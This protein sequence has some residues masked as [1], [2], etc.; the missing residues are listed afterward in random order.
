VVTAERIERTA[1]KNLIHN[2]EYIRKVLPFL[3]AEYF[4][5]RNEKIIFS[6]I[7]KFISQYNKPP[8]KETL[9]ID[10]GKRKDL[11]EKEYQNIV[12]LISTLNKEEIDLEWLV[13]TTERFCKDRAIHNAVME[14]I[15]IIDG[16]DKNHTPE[17]I[18][19][20]LKDA[21]AV[22]FDNNVGHDYLADIEKRFDFYHKKE[23]RIAFDLDY[24]NRATKGGLPNK[25]LNVAL[26]GTGVGKTLF[27]CHQAAAALN[28]NKN[29]LYITM[30]M[31]EERIAERIDAN[32]LGVS[33][34]DL[35]MLNK[36]MF[37]DKVTQLQS[38]TTGTVIIKEYP[39]AGAGANHYR[40]LVNE[41]AL[42]K[43]FKP[44]IIFID[45][46]NICAS[47]RFKAGANV[48]S[49]TYIKAIAEELRGLAVEL[50]VPIVTATQTT[51]TGFVSTDI[52]LEDTSES[53][54][55]PAT[56]DFMFAL[57]SSEELEKAGQMLVKQ[58]KNRYNDPTMNRKF[59]IGVDRSRMKLFDIEQS[60]QNLIQ[61]E[62]EKYVEHN[63]K[64]EETTEEKYK[65]FQNIQF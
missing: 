2:E 18:P 55:L 4:D 29:V 13:N 40:A 11:N 52:G 19:E 41:L 54:G 46:I 47:S 22:S 6:E 27:M 64:N 21:L 12:D 57:I 34:E 30:E 7:E 33:M 17:A 53:F 59:I 9:Q 38:K 24:F 28:D 50:D 8:T 58:L 25:T 44:D 15:H 20:I 10:I 1:L 39:T 43:S 60:A 31:A 49:Y 63:I 23:N 62:Q 61:P 3:K 37:S 32:L 48:N 42:K 51:R 35:H 56:A 5:D 36:K 65:K 45:Y 16:R 26:A 14:G